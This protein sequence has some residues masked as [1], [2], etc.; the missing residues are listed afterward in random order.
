MLG[1]RLKDL[2]PADAR[3]RVMFWIGS[4]VGIELYPAGDI[5]PST[6]SMY[7]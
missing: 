3:A 5:S 1:R 2:L 7:T 4:K 6:Q